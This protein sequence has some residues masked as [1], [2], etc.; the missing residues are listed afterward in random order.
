MI[1]AY[2][3]LEAAPDYHLPKIDRKRKYTN[4]YG[5]IARDPVGHGSMAVDHRYM[6]EGHISI[7]GNHG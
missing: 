5:R 7:G 1:R 4:G 3:T 2:A 6:R